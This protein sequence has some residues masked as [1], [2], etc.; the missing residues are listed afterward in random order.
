MQ[1]TQK[2]RPGHWLPKDRNIISA[3]IRNLMAEIADKPKPLVPPIQEFKEMVESDTA[4]NIAI[5]S[6]FKEAEVRKPVTPLGTPEVG[7]FD[8]FLALL[9]AIMTK[10]P[11]FT[12]CR[13]N[14]GVFEPCGLIGFPINALLDWPMGTASGYNVFANKLVN[15]Q[16]KNILSHWSVFLRSEDS[17]YVLVEGKPN[18]TP[19]VIPWLSETA[20]KEMVAVACQGSDDPNCED[21]KFE[22][23]FVCD[24][25][26]PYYGFG[27]WD[28]FFTRKFKK[29]VRPVAAPKDEDIIANACES[30]PLRT[31]TGVKKTD[32]FWLKKQPYSL[33]DML[34][35]DPLAEQFIGGTVYQAF[36]SALSYHRWHSP[37]DGT[38]EKAYVV[39]GTYYLENLYEGFRNP[40]GADDSAPNDSQ[41]F[42]SAVATRAVIFIRAKNPKIGLMC[43]IAIGMAEVSSNEIT[44]KP[45]DKVKK[46]DQL[47][48]FHF[49]GST[50]C[51]LFRKEVD[52]I[53][54]FH[55]QVPNLDAHNIP[56]RSKIAK[57][58]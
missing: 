20:R 58:C 1:S 50:H 35:W 52:L 8:Q 34:D 51:L 7:D 14:M 39:N 29:G 26:D 6:M 32:K 47:G 37:V 36:L 40:Q 17:R 41:A 46:G 49:G 55:G 48:M 53:F 9:N 33:Y 21:K 56:V 38:I 54:D 18:A 30:A 44:V 4:L 19:K 11:E 2:H 13:N 10:A 16:F 15:K 24:P 42:L 23:F 43:F 3:W 31:R 45:G 28:D 57:V 22:D 5:F 25:K 12:E 27:C